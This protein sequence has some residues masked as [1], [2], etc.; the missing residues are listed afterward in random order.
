RPTT[1]SWLD[2]DLQYDINRQVADRVVV[3]N[4][5]G[6]VRDQAGNGVS[7]DYLNTRDDL[8]YVAGTVDIAWWRPIYLSY[9]HR[10]D[11]EGG[12]ALE[13]VVNLEYR[14]QCWS[15]FFTVRDRLDDTEYLVSFALGG[16]GKVADLG[17]RLRRSED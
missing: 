1:W 4:I 16:L 11:L 7:L 13:K 5:R 12:R 9:L 17:G 3:L 14:A 15:L 6:G 8:N 10:H 2:L